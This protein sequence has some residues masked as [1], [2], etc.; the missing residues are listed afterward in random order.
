MKRS[1]SPAAV[2]GVAAYCVALVLRIVFVAEERHNPFFL[3]RLIDEIDYH[4][5]AERFLAGAWPGHEA[6]FRPPLYPLLLGGQYRLFGDDLVTTKLVQ[7]AVGSSAA[8]LT[9]WLAFR[10][11]GS[12]ALSLTAG[13]IV[14]AC[15]TLIYYD[16]QLLAASLDVLLTVATV[17]LVL[18]A[19][20]SR[21]IAAWALAGA[22][23]GLA[24]TNRGGMLLFAPV[25]AAWAC[26]TRDRGQTLRS[27]ARPLGAFLLAVVAAIGPVAWWNARYDDR[28][29]GAYAIG[30]PAPPAATASVSTTIER[31]VTHRFCALG[32]A[33]GV[34]LYLGNIPELVDVNSNDNLAHFARFLEINAEPWHAGV[35]TAS[36]HSAWFEAKTFAY[37]RAHRLAWLRLAG[38]KLLD[39]V[40]G[41]EIP[42]G[43]T[44]YA[45]RRSSYILSLLLWEGP[46][47]FPSGLLLPLGLAGAWRLRHDRRVLLVALAMTT[48]LLFV[49][50]F[51]VT[52]RYR[53]PALPLAAVL[54]TAFVASV[55]ERLRAR[56]LLP[57]RAMAGAAALVVL[58]VV[59]NLHLDRQPTTRGAIEQYD[60]ANDLA[61]EGRIPEA[62]EGY[63]AMLALEP[64][65][66]P[67]H[68]NLGRLLQDQ[69]RLD[70]AGAEYREALVIDGRNARAHNNLGTLLLERG[71]AAGA[72]VEFRASLAIEPGYRHAKENLELAEKLAR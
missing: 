55:A 11:L 4:V 63:R 8:P 17:A 29:E 15:G 58:V 67:A 66:S 44:L 42:R 39:L 23:L 1:A 36:G 22:V 35:S 69:G 33:G 50:A 6:F 12:V 53:L 47:R 7:A 64:E 61:N 14:A 70:E 48:Q 68:N 16:A 71:D 19:D 3:H 10:S 43:T 26:A 30:A 60:L 57:G 41:Y 38:R 21:H 62:I 32:W 28:P 54:G 27:L 2:A 59:A 20:R 45:D 65:Y 56:S 46:V 13:L 51:F 52:A 37:V 9:V 5:M 25:V 72:A 24:A 40:N 49:G 31:I 18:R 34:N